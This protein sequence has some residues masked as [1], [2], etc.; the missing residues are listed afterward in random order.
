MSKE[1][2]EKDPHEITSVNPNLT[3]T[4]GTGFEVVLDFNEIRDYVLYDAFGGKVKFGELF[5]KKKT[6][7]VFVRVSGSIAYFVNAWRRVTKTT[8]P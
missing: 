6:I 5:S 2:V 1:E 8:Q 7:V 4:R 3:M